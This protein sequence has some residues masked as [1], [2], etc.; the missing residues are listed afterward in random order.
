MQRKIYNSKKETAA[1]FAEFLMHRI[2]RAE[3][4]HIALSGGSTP[5]M[6][7]DLLATD[8]LDK[9]HWE[10]LYVYWGDERCV[11]PTSP[12][13]N[14]GM[15]KSHLLDFAPIPRDQVFRMQGELDPDVG[16]AEYAK[17]LRTNLKGSIPSFDLVI[18]GMGDDG[19]T[20][21]IFPHQIDLWSKKGLCVVAEHPET[22]QKRVSITGEVINAGAEVVFLVTGDSKATKVGEIF[23][24]IG[25]YQQYP[26]CL[27][28]PT[29]GK[30]TWFLDRDAAKELV[31]N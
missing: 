23:N 20:A 11:P 16:A 6:L 26:A 24:T 31:L 2:N 18:L 25:A 9:I 29:S 14:Y 17:V 7:F 5:K 21:S 19:H 3:T 27:V 15:T 13:S 1:A 4:Y 28:Q 22:R 10:K 12:E 8:Y 30:L